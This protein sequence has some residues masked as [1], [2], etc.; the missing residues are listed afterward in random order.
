MFASVNRSKG[1]GRP[2]RN[3]S[4]TWFELIEYRIFALIPILCSLAAAGC[5]SKNPVHE[6]RHAPTGIA[7]GDVVAFILTKYHPP[8]GTWWDAGADESEHLTTERE[9]VSCVSEALEERELRL[10]VIPPEKLREAAFPGRKIKE[11]PRDPEAILAA[12]AAGGSDGAPELSRLRYVML[13]DLTVSE[14]AP[15]A[16]NLGPAIGLVVTWRRSVHLGAT[17]LDL[18]NER[19]AGRLVNSSGG[20][21]GGGVAF[22]YIVPVPIM[23]LADPDGTACHELGQ[24]LVRFLAE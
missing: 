15:K 7:A 13:L 19:I 6:V 1:L 22:L 23:A 4:R 3:A 2:H 14:S 11:V 21:R 16:E 9:L 10:E 17:V 12:L 5:A 20:P 24:A 8:G 18:I